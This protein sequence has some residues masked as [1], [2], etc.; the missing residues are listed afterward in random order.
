MNFKYSQTIK[1]FFNVYFT[2]FPYQLYNYSNQ[3]SNFAML[4]ISNGLINSQKFFWLANIGSI[5]L[6]YNIK[7]IDLFYYNILMS[8]SCFYLYTNSFVK[9]INIIKYI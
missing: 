4:G 6:I 8:T 9:L 5:I 7:N 1:K 3:V 2:N